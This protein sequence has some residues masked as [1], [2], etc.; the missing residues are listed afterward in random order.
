MNTRS[1]LTKV[2]SPP[3]LSRS[4]SCLIVVYPG[5]MGVLCVGISLVSWMVSTVIFSESAICVSSAILFLML[6]VLH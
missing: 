5:M 6:F 3:P 2:I 4:R 1:V